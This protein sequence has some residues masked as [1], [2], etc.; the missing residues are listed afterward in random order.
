MI[1]LTNT[2]FLYIAKQFPYLNLLNFHNQSFKACKFINTILQIGTMP[3]IG[4]AEIY[5]DT[6]KLQSLC[7]H[8]V[9]SIASWVQLLT[10][11]KL[12]DIA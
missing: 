2:E 4:R 1:I 12:C 6:V 9:H 10:L 5:T 8:S 11:T 3:V 7:S